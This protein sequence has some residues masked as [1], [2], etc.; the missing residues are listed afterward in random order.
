MGVKFAS[1]YK[2][3]I[4]GTILGELGR[5]CESPTARHYWTLVPMLAG[6]LTWPKRQ[7]GGRRIGLNPRTSQFAAKRTGLPVHTRRIASD[8]AA[9]GALML[10]YLLT[11]WNIYRLRLLFSASCGLF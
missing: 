6:S 1:G 10:L 5:V 3:Y 7:V 2:D 4:F 9:T 8:L 11:C